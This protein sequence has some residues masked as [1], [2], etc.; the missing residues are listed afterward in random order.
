MSKVLNGLRSDAI[1]QNWNVLRYVLAVARAGSV[2]GAARLLRES[3]PTVSR[4][5]KMLETELGVRLFDRRP[6]GAVITADGAAILERVER[7]ES[8]TIAIGETVHGRDGRL[9]GE[10][11][12]AAPCGL[13]TAIVAP[14]VASFAQSNPE[15]RIDL[16]LGSSKLNLLNR[17][18]DV[19]VRIGDPL[20]DALIGKKLGQVRFGLYA[21]EGYLADRGMPQ[22]PEELNGH[23]I[24][25]SAGNL[26]SASQSKLL[27]RIAPSAHRSFRAEN[28]VA[29]AEA[30][31]SGI[32]IVALP[33]Y[34]GEA[35]AELKPVLSKSVGCVDDCW[36]LTHPDLV[37]LA[38]I[39][40]TMNFLA[41]TTKRALAV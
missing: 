5:L 38:R 4:Q 15:I 24:I 3:P 23:D 41:A 35:R 37:G 30:A 33:R 25:D 2:T 31:K 28:V 13:G 18:A 1:Q 22:R 6:N 40:A 12:V 39:R 14:V 16:Q 36:L 29:Q 17:D 11:S 34:V 19:A 8:E 7:I 9:T 32:G 21:S 20:Q 27:A 10:V 26:A